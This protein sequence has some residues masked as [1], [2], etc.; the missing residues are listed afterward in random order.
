[1]ANK[2]KSLAQARVFAGSKDP[3]EVVQMM[4]DGIR[5][6]E[7]VAVALGA[8]HADGKVGTA[9]AMCGDE[10]ALSVPDLL[11]AVTILRVRLEREIE[12]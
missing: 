10:E 9:F 3:A 4:L 7:I 6:G 11:L 5:A 12:T 1:V 2:V 8:V